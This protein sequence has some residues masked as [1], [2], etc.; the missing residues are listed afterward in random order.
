MKT[1]IQFT[2]I[3]RFHFD[4]SM[5]ASERAMREE[6][7]EGERQ[8]KPNKFTHSHKN[9]HTKC[10]QFH[11][12]FVVS[13]VIGFC[14]FL[15]LWLNEPNN[16]CVIDN[17]IQLFRI[18]FLR[19]RL[20]K[21]CYFFLLSQAGSSYAKCKLAL[22]FR[23]KRARAASFSLV[24]ETHQ[25]TDRNQLRERKTA[26]SRFNSVG[27]IIVIDPEMIIIIVNLLL[28]KRK[29]KEWMLLSS[30]NVNCSAKLKMIMSIR[31]FAF[32]FFSACV[33]LDSY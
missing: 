29:K 18:F 5:Q 6:G 13:F 9:K 3:D 20:D 26:D 16:V 11:F 25:N 14:H 8:R 4:K 10:D 17:K 1:K 32:F 31:S 15:P 2:L 33:F 30:S 23:L 7:N 28:R 24:S 22:I 19:L 21:R 12:G 27:G